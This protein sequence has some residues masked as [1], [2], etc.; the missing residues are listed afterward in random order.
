M[1]YCDVY[2]INLSGY[3]NDIT[4]YFAKVLNGKMGWC[5]L[6]LIRC[7]K[8]FHDDRPMEVIDF[9]FDKHHNQSS[10]FAMLYKGQKYGKQLMKIYKGDGTI[11]CCRR[12][13]HESDKPV[14]KWIEGERYGFNWIEPIETI[15]N[16]RYD[17]CDEYA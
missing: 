2:R 4:Y 8:T 10:Y 1:S 6:N 12:I 11:Y 14:Y 15:V 9:D 7:I 17:R 3:D 16:K 5:C 13:N